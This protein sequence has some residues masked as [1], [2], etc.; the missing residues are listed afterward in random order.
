MIVHG[1]THGGIAQ[2]VG[3]ALWE[4][5]VIDPETGQPLAAAFTEYGMPRFDNLPSFVTE[6]VEVISPTNPLGVKAGGEGGTTPAPAV[7][8]SAVEDALAEYG[9]PDISMPFTPFK[10]WSAI[11]K[12]RATAQSGTSLAPSP[13]RVREERS[14]V[15]GVHDGE[16]RRGGARGRRLHPAGRVP[17]RAPGPH[18]VACRLRHHPVRL[19]RGAHRR[20][21]GEILHRARRP[22]RRTFDHDHRRARQGRRA[23]PG[24]ESLSRAPRPAVRLTARPA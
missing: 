22:G 5:C 3:Q 18:R 8:T 16:R 23:P 11:Q 4:G 13:P 1:Q 24:A 14:D 12:G 19:L 7:I 20:R 9:P 6:I 17:S 2:G 10:I 15:P 21:L